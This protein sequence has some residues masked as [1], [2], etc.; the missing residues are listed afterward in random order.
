MAVPVDSPPR[1]N[2]EKHDDLV[3]DE[4]EERKHGADSQVSR[5]DE[6]NGFTLKLVVVIFVSRI[7]TSSLVNCDTD[8]V[9]YRCCP[10]P[11]DSASGLFRPLQL[12]KANSRRN[13]VI[14]SLMS[15]GVSGPLFF[16]TNGQS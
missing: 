16:R 12:C 15:G 11:L 3:K 9:D 2:D 13:S 7:T 14:R 1:H 8:D 6:E 5:A 10:A 4:I